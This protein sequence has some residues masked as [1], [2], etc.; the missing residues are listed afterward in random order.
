MSNLILKAENISKHYRLGVIGSGSFKEDLQ[1]FWKNTFSAGG[2]KTTS[3]INTEP[4]A[5]DLWA[6]KDI[7]FEIMKG[8]VVGFV[9]KNGAG[10][11][12]LLKVLSRITLPTTGTIKGKGRIASLLEV[13][14]GFHAELTGRENIFL[15]GQILGMQKKEIISKFDEI[16]AFSGIERFLDTPVKRYSSGMYVRLA[17]AIAAH[18]DPEI[19]IVD[20]VLAVGDAEFQKKCL[21][22]MKQVSAEE[23]KT[24]LFVSHNSQALKNLCTKAIYLEKGRLIDMGNT[25]DVITN[26]LKREQTL[27]LHRIYADPDTAPGNDSIRIKR[28]EM[29]PQY[30]SGS[31]I[32]DIRTPL[33]IDFEF[34]YLPKEEMDLGVS[35][36]LNTVM[37]ECIFDVDSLARPYKKGLIK[38]QCTIPGDFLNNGSYSINLI[39]VKNTSSALFEFEDCLS[40]DVEDFRANTA[41]YGDW[42]G[43]VRPKFKVQLQQE[44]I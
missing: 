18:L 25:Q 10:K 17:F 35:I 39:F 43:A 21:G 42:P 32:I 24:V 33:V 29:L 37:G 27:Y 7:D 3:S 15:N 22:K 31:N 16:V 40:F 30:L 38:G 5:N 19:L 9:G 36:A 14:T 11:S 26:Y 41:W 28:V 34:W 4:K 1:N 23:G 2:N 44:E 12:T 20:E 13:G 6:L 8:D